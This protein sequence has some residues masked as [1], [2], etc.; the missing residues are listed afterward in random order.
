MVFDLVRATGLEPA[1][2]SAQD[3][4]SCTSANS[5]TPAYLIACQIIIRWIPL[6]VKFKNHSSEL[7]Q[8]RLNIVTSAGGSTPTEAGTKVRTHR[9]APQAST[10]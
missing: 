4:K 3:P 2:L 7:V 6:F 8:L 9:N 5:A 1:R 10:R